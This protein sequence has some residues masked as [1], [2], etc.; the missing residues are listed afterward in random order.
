[1][2]RLSSNSG[3]NQAV[4][5]FLKTPPIF[6]YLVGGGIAVC[7]HMA[8][9]IGL[10][11]LI[12]VVAVVAS[13][14]GLIAGVIVNYLFQYYVTFRSS[15]RGHRSTAWRFIAVTSFT[16]LLNYLMFSALESRMH[17]VIAQAVTILAIFL[18]NFG[19][20][21]AFTFQDVDQ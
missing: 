6:Q 4:R 13:T 11:E 20:N 15:S 12:G 3:V 18:V 7:V 9:L 8:I 16:L 14:I 1:M 19:I 21:K 10:V 2:T 5:L 17:Y